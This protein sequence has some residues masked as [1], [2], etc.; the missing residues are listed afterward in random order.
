M[1]GQP[2]DPQVEFSLD[3]HSQLTT[4]AARGVLSE[5]QLRIVI[6]YN[7]AQDL[8]QWESEVHFDNCAFAEGAQHIRDE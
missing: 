5:S 3:V 4:E 7:L 8:R 1:T 6:T 2:N